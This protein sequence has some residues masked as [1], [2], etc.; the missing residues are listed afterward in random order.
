MVDI[1]INIAELGSGDTLISTD[2]EVASEPTLKEKALTV[3]LLD[4]IKE[5]EMAIMDIAEGSQLFE[6]TNE[7]MDSIKDSLI[8]KNGG[9]LND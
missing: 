1:I 9:R 7:S 2:I 3:F 6:G 4:R 8:K 5:W